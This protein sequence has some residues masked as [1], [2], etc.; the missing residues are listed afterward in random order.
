MNIPNIFKWALY[1][2][3]PRRRKLLETVLVSNVG[4]AVIHLILAYRSHSL[5]KAIVGGVLW[6]VIVPIF[7]VWWVR[8]MESD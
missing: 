1:G 7:S 4:V 8:N 6:L 5:E 3:G 2:L